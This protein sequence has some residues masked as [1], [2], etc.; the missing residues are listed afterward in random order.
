MHKSA[1]T[2]SPASALSQTSR[3]RSRLARDVPQT[4][5]GAP[6]TA[7]GESE[8]RARLPVRVPT[9]TSLFASSWIAP[10]GSQRYSGGRR[11]GCTAPRFSHADAESSSSEPPAPKPE[12]L[13]L[14]ARTALALAGRR[15]ISLRP[16]ALPALPGTVPAV[17]RR[18]GI[19]KSGSD[20]RGQ[21]Q[22]R[23]HARE[24]LATRDLFHIAPSLPATD[25]GAAP[26]FR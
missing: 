13:R 16:G 19:R 6:A 23:E 17:R 7:S 12:L 25:F 15:P 3:V 20:R 14:V 8:P 24:R 2:I 10:A 11:G 1:S 9:A 18:R 22:A 4:S 21:G 26:Q 5:H